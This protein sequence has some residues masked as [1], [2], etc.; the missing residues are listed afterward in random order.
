MNNSTANT[1][2]TQL[3]EF[4]AQSKDKLI[5]LKQQMILAE[6]EYM[7]EKE[8][9]DKVQLKYKE[10]QEQTKKLDLQLKGIEE[11]IVKAKKRKNELDTEIK[12]VSSKLMNVDEEIR[13]M[14]SQVEFKVKHVKDDVERIKLLERN[15]L[16]QVAQA[17]EKEQ[18][19]NKQFKES[20]VQMERNI[21]EIYTEIE[22]MHGD[23]GEKMNALLKD[24]ADM[25][26]FLSEI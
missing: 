7:Q 19:K 24:T 25:N 22:K 5:R 8:Q 1:V 9:N 23:E 15:Q 16:A 3:R 18:E 26:K 17:I 13:Y 12:N 6:G 14:N 10:V 20:I 11:K 21:K 2:Q 4:Y